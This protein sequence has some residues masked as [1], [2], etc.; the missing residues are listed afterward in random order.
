MDEP[1][2]RHQQQR[3]HHQQA[4]HH[5]GMRRSEEPTEQGVGDRHAGHQQHAQVVARAERVL[6]EDPACHHAA[7]NIE[8][9]EHQ[10]QRTRNHPQ[11]AGAILETIL[12]E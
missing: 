6:E 4:L 11:H 2:N 5:V 12:Q 3:H 7:R 1:E 10:D 9:E 8:R